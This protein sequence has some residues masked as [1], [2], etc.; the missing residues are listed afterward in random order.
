M[1]E[2][3]QRRDGRITLEKV[4]KI[5]MPS[6]YGSHTADEFTVGTDEVSTEKI[7][8]NCYS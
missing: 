5:T 1:V 4:P 2:I 3:N 8:L 6:G 7:R